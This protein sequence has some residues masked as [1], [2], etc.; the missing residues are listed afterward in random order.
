MKEDVS[1]GSPRAPMSTFYLL[2]P[3]PVLGERLAGFLRAVLPGLDW[4]VQTRVN[5]TEAI[6]AAA[7]V[8]DDVFVIYREELPEGETPSE[9]LT[10]AFGAESGDEV[11]EV[12]PGPH[13]GELTTRR[14]RVGA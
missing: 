1:R 12:R 10:T 8:H 4:D 3:R 5:L 2:P 9:A 7:E 6:S 13:P 14:W 11:V